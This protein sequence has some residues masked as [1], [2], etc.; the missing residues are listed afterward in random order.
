MNATVRHAL[1]KGMNYI[2]FVFSFPEYLNN[3][4]VALS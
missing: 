2:D 1:D 3:L 4:G